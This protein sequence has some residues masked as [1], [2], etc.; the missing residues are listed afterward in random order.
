MD[1]RLTVLPFYMNGVSHSGTNLGNGCASVLNTISIVHINHVSFTRR[2]ENIAFTFQ[3]Q[4][5]IVRKE[6][7]QILECLALHNHISNS[8][9]SP[10]ITH[11]EETLHQVLL[12]CGYLIHVSHACVAPRRHLTMFLYTLE[13][14]PSPSPIP[15]VSS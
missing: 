11:Q 12:H 6:K 1:S 8:T 7:I 13:Y 5:Q 10:S 14:I 4:Y 15:W 2:P 9:I 3:W